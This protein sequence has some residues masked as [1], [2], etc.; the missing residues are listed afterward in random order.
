MN[1]L[2]ITM[3]AIAGTATVLGAYCAKVLTKWTKRSIAPL[4]ALAAGIILGTAVIELLPEAIELSQAWPYWLLGGFLL[5]FVLEK[6]V[7][8]HACTA[9]GGK[10]HEHISSRTA[11]LGIGLHSLVDG[12]LIGLGFE[13]STAVGIIATLAVFTHEFPEGIFSYTLLAHGGVEEKKALR[14]SWLIALA[15][16]V[17]A[18]VTL[19]LINNWSS[20][21]IGS[22][23]A[24][25]AGN[26]TYIATVDLIPETNKA[27]ALSSIMLVVV[28]IMSVYVLKTVL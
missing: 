6:F 26:F 16:P 8:A 9:Q 1:I 11:V 17:G 24:L 25:T 12:L 21:T 20:S 10:G 4:V 18:I 27:S 13:V 22:L 23:L 19:L 2:I 3:A 5:F 7:V 14:Y 15:T 28:G